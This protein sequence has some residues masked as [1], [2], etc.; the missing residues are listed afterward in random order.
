MSVYDL[1]FIDMDIELWIVLEGSF[2]RWYSMVISLERIVYEM[3][4]GMISWF[5]DGYFE[6]DIIG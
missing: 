1:S 2:E 4:I 5:W 3:V 6:F